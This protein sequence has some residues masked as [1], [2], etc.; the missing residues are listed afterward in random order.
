MSQQP[1]DYK[2]TIRVK[3]EYLDGVSSSKTMNYIHFNL[4]LL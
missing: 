2:I 3:P 1:L 4:I